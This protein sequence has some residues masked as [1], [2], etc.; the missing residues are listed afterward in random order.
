MKK[1]LIIPVAFLFGC[2][3]AD[4]SETVLLCDPSRPCPEGYSCV[5]QKCQIPGDSSADM[6]VAV[7][8]CKDGTGKN[9]STNGANV[10]WACPGKFS[11]GKPANAS[12]LCA[13]GWSLCKSGASLDKSICKASAGFF[14]ADVP[15]KRPENKW[16][17]Y[18]CGNAV[19]KEGPGFSG[20]GK[21]VYGDWVIDSQT[22]ND[23]NQGRFDTNGEFRVSG[24]NLSLDQAVTSSNSND[25]VLCCKI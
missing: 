17:V 22:C 10:I 8:G 15:V 11:A 21:N 3:S 18:S 7:A 4:L 12:S 9:V 5:N 20:C 23:F 16:D 6:S 25:G 19:G 2:F 24:S 1:L 13:T 14:V